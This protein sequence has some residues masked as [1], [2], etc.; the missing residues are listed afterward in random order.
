MANHE[1]YGE[2]FNDTFKFLEKII[3]ESDLELFKSTVDS[4]ENI[5]IQNSYGWS[6][7]HMTIRRD[8]REM[9][10]YLLE[11]NADINITDGVGWTPVMEA[12]MDDRRE[13]MYEYLK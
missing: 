11:K 7:L 2:V 1:A 5:N 8:E 12:V 6:L 13:N 10:A 9:F 3:Y 4:L